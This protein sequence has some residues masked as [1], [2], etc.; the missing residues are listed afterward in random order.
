MYLLLILL[1]IGV[2]VGPLLLSAINLDIA[3]ALFS[4]VLGGL[5]S[6]IVGF[7]IL[8]IAEEVALNKQDSFISN[9][10][11]IV[12]V[13]NS[14]N[15]EGSVSGFL[16]F[17]GT[18]EEKEYYFVMTKREDGGF[19]RDKFPVSKTIIYE[20]EEQSPHVDVISKSTSKGFSLLEQQRL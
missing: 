2:F 20:D 14:K 3:D 4:C 17:T 6:L 19:K 10:V 13:N 8:S 18:I 12:S 1:I 5:I 9:T 16:I 7:A 15:I 11:E